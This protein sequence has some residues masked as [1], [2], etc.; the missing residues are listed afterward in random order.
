MPGPTEARWRL[1]RGVRLRHDRVR[2]ATVLLHPEGV[3]RVNDTG[4][5]ILALCDGTRDESA[6]ADALA[7]SFESVVPQDVRDFLAQLAQRRLTEAVVDG[8]EQ[9]I[10]GATDEGAAD[11]GG[12]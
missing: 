12:G 5:A 6:I 7:E 2:A 11:E 3:L 1:R 10:E 4:A 9:L 8:G